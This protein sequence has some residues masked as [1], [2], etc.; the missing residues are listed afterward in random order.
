[1]KFFS[2]SLLFLLLACGAADP[3]VADPI[4]TLNDFS[5]IVELQGRTVALSGVERPVRLTILPD[6]GVLMCYEADFRSDKKWI[7]FYSLDSMKLIRS[8]INN[9]EA[10]GQ[11]LGVFQLQ[12]DKRNSGEIFIT[13][14][15]KQQIVVYKADSLIAGNEKP[16]KIIGM[17]FYGYHGRLVTDNRLM[18]SVVINNAYDFIDTRGSS[19]NHSRMLLNKYRND[20]SIIDSFGFYPKTTDDI[21]PQMLDQVL[22]GCLSISDD[23]QYL[24][25]NGL[26]TDYLAVYDTSG[27]LISSTIGPGELNVSYQVETIGKGERIIPMSGHR[28]YGSRAQASKNSIYLLY[29][30]KDSKIHDSHTA[31]LFRFN[32]ALKPEVRYKFDIPIF[33]FQIDWRTKILY[34][35]RREGSTNQMVIYQL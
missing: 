20:L 11:L 8:V 18:R 4:F 22:N 27:K 19:T 13:D 34:G 12:Y 24:V 32:T 23:N 29:D 2:F 16:F 17:P 1:M 33:D 15:V 28:G 7:H 10:D 3:H 26:T 9:G 35:L 31:N 14:I 21:S 25:F 6:K 30:G 5:K